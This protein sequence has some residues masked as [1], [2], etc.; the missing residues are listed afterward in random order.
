M[1]ELSGLSV[2]GLTVEC[3]DGT[4]SANVNSITGS[5]TGEDGTCSNS[6]T[7][8]TL[9]FTNNS[10]ADK[11]LTFD[12]D[13]TLNDG[14]CF[15]GSGS[16][17]SDTE[18]EEETENTE[19][20]TDTSEE[21]T[22]ET[23]EDT[24]VSMDGSGSYSVTL[25]DG[26]TLQIVI[27]SGAGSAYTTTISLTNISLISD[28]YVTVT[29][30]APENGSYTVDG[31]EI[32]ED[33][34]I[35]RHSS[36]AFIVEAKVTTKGYKFSDWHNTESDT[37]VSINL[38]GNLH[39]DSDVTIA[40]LFVE[41][42]IPL[43]S[44]AGSIFRDLN[45]AVD[46]AVENATTIIQLISS[47]TLLSD[48]VV[49][50][51]ICLSIP[52]DANMETYTT[53]CS[54]VSSSALEAGTS[55]MTLIVPEDVTLT[56]YGTVAVNGRQ[57]S[58][59]IVYTGWLYGDYGA[60][61]VNGTVEIYGIL[62]A[63]GYVYGDGAV[64]AKDGATVYQ[65]FG[66]KGWRGGSATS[67]ALGSV[68][69]INDFGLVNIACKSV[70]EYG[71]ILNTQMAVYAG[72]ATYHATGMVALGTEEDGGMFI[73]SE[74]ASITI[75][76]NWKT[77]QVTISGNA[78]LAYLTVKVAGVS[79]TSSD[80]ILPIPEGWH[81]TIEPGAAVEVQY[82]CK[83]QPGSSLTVAEGGMLTI[84][85]GAITGIWGAEYDSRYNAMLT[86]SELPAAILTVNG[87]LVNNG[88]L[89]TSDPDVG[90]IV[91]DVYKVSANGET[92][93]IG[94]LMRSG[95]ATSATAV[96]FYNVDFEEA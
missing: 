91:S 94:E 58:G 66:A 10:G 71:S 39:F 79:I 48:S 64:I 35:T 32:T 65:M 22:E 83:L 44:T 26:V 61:E 56:V 92:T 81:I 38:S 51:D 36:E 67:T 25:A 8:G 19:E 15:I 93:E 70:Y 59:L 80:Y 47:G 29:F 62:A 21:D 95:S 76:S 75:D 42:D 55:Y 34:T 11:L 41:K 27:T 17:S 88:V 31:V 73:L 54:I 6:S 60:L 4:W 90:N 3:T 52:M 96:T 23:E 46:Y 86:T 45:A 50:E 24:S 2:D 68:F 82:S 53:E 12:Y 57:Q 84:A 69:P 89:C 85:E 78:V 63:W 5:V 7:T 20:D 18:T 43:F 13:I 49:P 28:T 1:A 72:S 30:L 33:V 16:T 37:S 74:G 77:A 14:S 40:A 87:T 9:V